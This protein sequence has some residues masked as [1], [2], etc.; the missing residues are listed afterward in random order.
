MKW[1]YPYGTPDTSQKILG[2]QGDP[3]KVFD[4]LAGF[5][6]SGVELFVRDPSDLDHSTLVDA[7]RRAGLTVAAIGTGPLVNEENLTLMSEHEEVR[8][9]TLSRA[10]SVVDL[11]SEVGAQVNVGKLRGS[12]GPQPEVSWSWLKEGL[13][14]LADYGAPKGV[15]ITIEPQNSSALNNINTTQ[16]GIDFITATGH[17]NIKLMVDT[18]HAELEDDWPALSYVKAGGLLEHVHFSD[19]DRRSPGQGQIDFRLHLATLRA[20]K[21][22]GYITFEISQGEDPLSTAKEALDYT[23]SLAY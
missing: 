8:S 4:A 23:A 16:Q 18:F 21:Y 7:L 9:A 2:A 6:Y 3:F 1:S 15:P 22:D 5:G 12:L 11:G 10:K 14:A 13:V 19:S 20:L 17:P